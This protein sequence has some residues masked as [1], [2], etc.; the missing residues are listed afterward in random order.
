[1]A[2]YLVKGNGNGK[3]V[4]RLVAK[5]KDGYDIEIIDICDGYTKK[6]KDKIGKE[7]LSTCLRTGY[8]MRIKKKQKTA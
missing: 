6:R 5:N 1:M 2:Y 7:L 8:L 3:T 4:M